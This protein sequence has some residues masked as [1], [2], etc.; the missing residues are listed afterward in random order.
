M[1]APCPPHSLHTHTHTH[2][3]WHCAHSEC[4]REPAHCRHCCCARRVGAPC[5]LQPSLHPQV[6]QP[7]TAASSSHNAK[8]PAGS[9]PTT[10]AFMDEPFSFSL[11]VPHEYD[12]FSFFLYIENPLLPV[13]PC[14]RDA[15]SSSSS[16][17]Q[18]IGALV[19][20]VS[21]RTRSGLLG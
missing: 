1:Q 8:R 16:W 17:V 3:K 15:A 9:Q 21:L 10:Q 20:G 2:D 19:A 18:G 7:L 11:S 14:V 4:A 5:A 13:G 12:L 6:R